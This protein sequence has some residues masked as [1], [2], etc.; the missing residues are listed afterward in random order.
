VKKCFSKS[1]SMCIVTECHGE[2]T[3]SLLES[4][5][6][7]SGYRI[8]F[9]MIYIDGTI[10]E[11]YISHLSKIMEKAYEGNELIPKEWNFE[12]IIDK[13]F[14]K[15]ERAR[16]FGTHKWRRGNDFGRRYSFLGVFE[17]GKLNTEFSDYLNKNLFELLQYTLVNFDN[18]EDENSITLKSRIYQSNTSK[19]IDSFIF[20]V[21]L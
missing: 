10:F 18:E 21:L 11:N 3:D 4:C 12:H 7:K 8:Y 5:K 20:K 19:K 6:Y 13:E 1:N 2:Y 14:V 9:P 16:L 17:D 15:H